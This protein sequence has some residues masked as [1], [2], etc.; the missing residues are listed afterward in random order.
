[1]FAAHIAVPNGFPIQQQIHG[2]ACIAASACSLI[3]ALGHPPPAQSLLDGHVQAGMRVLS[4]GFCALDAALK[5]LSAPVGATRHTPNKSQLV[6]WLMQQAGTHQGVLISHQVTG[7]AHITVLFHDQNGSWYRAD[8]GN[9]SI[10]TIQ[11]AGMTQN[12]AG[13]LAI[14][15]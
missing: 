7:G 8:P 5:N 2:H 3:S 14:I 4:N 1:M 6:Q 13:D 12:Y 15:A 11:L 10:S 9:G